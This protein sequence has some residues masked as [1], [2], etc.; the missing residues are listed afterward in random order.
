MRFTTITGSLYEVDTKAKKIRRLNGA[1]DPS[2]RMGKDG[3]WR[4]YKEIHP[5]IPVVGES[6]VIAWGDDV[7]LTEEGKAIVEGGGFGIPLTTTSPV[8]DVD[9]TVFN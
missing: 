3:Q 1:K 4:S 6:V 8:V 2:P 7:E 9:E 5:K